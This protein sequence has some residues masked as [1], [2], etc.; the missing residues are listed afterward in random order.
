M[1]TG[2][3]DGTAADIASPN[4]QPVRTGLYKNAQGAQGNGHRFD[5]VALLETQFTRTP[6]RRFTIGTGR[7]NAKCR[8]LVYC[9]C[10]QVLWHVYPD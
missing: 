3:I 6:N 7:R 10:H 1:I 5:T 8:K 9:W 4:Q 2:A